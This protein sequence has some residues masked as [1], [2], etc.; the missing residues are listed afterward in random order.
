M[1]ELLLVLLLITTALLASVVVH[2]VLNYVL[3]RKSSRMRLPP[4]PWPWPVVGNL[5]QLCQGGKNLHKTFASL[6]QQYG[7]IVY[8][9]LGS[10]HT[11][12][13]SSPVMAKEFLKTHDQ[14]FQYRP[15]PTLAAEILMGNKG[16]VTTGGPLSRHLRRICLT[17][18]FATKQLQS[19]ESMRTKEI[20][21]TINDIHME[22]EEGKVVDLKSR[23][24]S[25]GINIL[26]HMMFRKR[27]F[28]VD[29]SKHNE[30]HC[31]KEVT[32]KVP[33]WLGIL[34]ISDYIPSLRWLVRLQGIE[35][36]LHALRH[37]KSQF[38]QKLIAEH[39]NLTIE[40]DQVKDSGNENVAKTPKDFVDILLSAPQEDGTGN[41]SDET[42]ETLILEMLAG[43]AETSSLTIEWAMAELIRNPMIMKRAQMELETVVGMNRIIE[44]SDLHKLTYLQAVIKETLRLHPPGPLLVPHSSTIKVCGIA[45]D[46]DIP[47]HTRVMVNVWAMG[48]DPSIWERPFEFYPERFLQ[49]GQEHHHIATEIID[50]DENN[51]KLFPFGSG[52]RACPGRPLGILVAQIVLAR[53]LHSFHWVLPN[54]QEPNTLDMSEEFG[55]TLPRAQPLHLKAYPKLQAH[56]YK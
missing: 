38:I 43:G 14:E 34:I 8:L 45:K 26:T 5:L 4:G 15:K 11:V 44:E 50:M 25:L 23:L 18:L 47:P 6:A 12:V 22:S 19:F 30:I 32:T 20:N 17:E 35:A 9:R 37:K 31:F 36:S 29:E 2:L 51:F 48:R 21:N 52:R 3:L 39:K 1:S 13:V 49:Q 41:L 7:P 42:I 46:Y 24:S 54:H 16:M 27:Y 56:L 40:V 55:L 53:L 33:H 28:G 10:V